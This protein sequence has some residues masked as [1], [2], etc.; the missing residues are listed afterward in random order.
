MSAQGPIGHR[1]LTS[2]RGPKPAARIGRP[3]QESGFRFT[4]ATGMSY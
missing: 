3:A 2:A 1:V 4:P